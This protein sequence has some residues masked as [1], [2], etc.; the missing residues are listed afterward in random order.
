MSINNRVRSAR[1]STAG[2]PIALLA[3]LSACHIVMAGDAPASSFVGTKAGQVRDDNSLK[4]KLVWCPPGKFTM[5]SAKDEKGRRDD[6]TQVQVTFRKGFWLAQHEVKQVDWQRVMK[7]TPWSGKNNVK[8]GDDYAATYV[9]WYD[10]MNFCEHLTRTELNAGRLPVGC[11]YALPTESQWEYAC[12]AGTKSRFSF[13]G[14]DSDLAKHAWFT[15]N[16]DDADEQY[17][18]MVGQKR[19]NPWGL[20][21]IH[22]NVCEWCLP[23]DIPI[24]SPDSWTEVYRGGS[25]V[26]SARLCRSASRVRDSPNVRRFYLGFRVALE[27][28]GK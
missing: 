10:A 2:W 15:K 12:R 1:H 19:P 3:L 20:F 28:Y 16:A 26:G 6:E 23:D 18:H 8:E 11:T 5:G 25:W 24:G 21:D 14:D 13:G 9:N 4:M 17:A 22:G 27:Q 7:T